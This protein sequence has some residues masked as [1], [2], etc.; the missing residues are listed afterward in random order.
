MFVFD[1]WLLSLNIMFLRARHVV[2]NDSVSCLLGW[3]SVPWGVG[4]TL[5]GHLA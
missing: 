4:T 3:H 5:A 1:A 2:T